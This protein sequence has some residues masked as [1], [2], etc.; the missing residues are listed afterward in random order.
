MGGCTT[1]GRN[2]RM[3]FN[4][5][6]F[7]LFFAGLFLI[8]WLLRSRPRLQ[9][10]LLLG[11]GYYF[12]AYWNPKF[13]ALL[14]LSTVMDYA[15]GLWVDRAENPANRRAA[16]ALSITVNLGMLGYFKYYNFFAENLQAA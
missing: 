7:A 6:E 14:I 2:R 10:I 8:Y 13:L 12:Y 9:N 15:C 5:Y 4:S 1:Q 11:A 16:V 3:Q